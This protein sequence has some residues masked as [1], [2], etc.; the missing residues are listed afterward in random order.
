M[1]NMEYLTFTWYNQSVVLTEFP[2][3]YVALKIP[4]RDL[5]ADMCFSNNLQAATANNWVVVREAL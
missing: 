2:E 5:H 1:V 4:Q 3:L